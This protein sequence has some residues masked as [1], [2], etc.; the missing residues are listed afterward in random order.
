MSKICVVIII[1]IGKPI[2]GDRGGAREERQ[3]A[4]QGSGPARRGHVK[5]NAGK[6]P[7]PEI[8]RPRVLR[9]ARH[10]AGQVRDAAPRIDREHVGGQRHDRIRRVQADLLYDQS[11]LRG[12][13]DRRTGAQE[14]GSAR[15]SQGAGRSAGI[16]PGATR[17]GRAHPGARTGEA[18]P[19]EIPSRC[20]PEDDRASGGRKKNSAI[21]PL[22]E[23]SSVRL[24]S[25]VAQYETLRG[26]A[27]GQALPPEA[28]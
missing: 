16:Y 18:G 28:R 3:E 14:A 20:A 27:L 6:G 13:G 24:S 4:S 23:E 17:R 5:P 21:T 19:A 15:S 2:L 12:R 9:S 25:I 11:Q 10:R 8:P 26:A 22:G 7:R 1:T